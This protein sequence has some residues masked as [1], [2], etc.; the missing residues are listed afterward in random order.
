MASSLDGIFADHSLVFPNPT[1][2]EGPPD[3]YGNPTW[4]PGEPVTVRCYL[5]PASGYGDPV[6]RPEPGVD[7][8]T[9]ALKGRCIDPVVMPPVPPGTEADLTY[10]GI[11]G[12]FKLELAAP[13]ILSEVDEA[14]GESIRGLWWAL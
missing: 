11:K 8:I 13:S 7:R 14:L 5:K 9:L 10:G 2:V 12:V 1:A 4:L 3:Q 6:I